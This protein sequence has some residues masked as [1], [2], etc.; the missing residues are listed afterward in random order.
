MPTQPSSHDLLKRAQAG[1]RAAFEELVDEYRPRLDTLIGLRLRSNLR[2]FVEVEDVA[3][4]T[5]LRAYRS[6]GTAEFEEKYAL[7]A[8]LGTIAERV[9]IDL[10]RHRERR[11]RDVPLDPE[12]SREQVSPSK[13]LRRNERFE[14]LR[15]A[16]G[17]MSPEHR[18]VILLA[19]IHGLPLK[20]ISDRMNRSPAAVAQLLSR[21]LRKLRTA[22]GETESLHLPPWSLGDQESPT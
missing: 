22:F 18:E 10:A 13:G 21:A 6:I 9:I 14:R 3:Q 19:R 1:D 17:D 12:V 8:W 7:F 11:G 15:L 2:D 5:L 4:E 20:D 16:L